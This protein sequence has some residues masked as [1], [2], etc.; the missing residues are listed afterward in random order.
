MLGVEPFSLCRKLG[1][2]SL[3]RQEDYNLGIISGERLY[4]KP[5]ERNGRKRIR[6]L[7]EGQGGTR[8]D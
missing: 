7:R 1:F 5:P 6:Y 8:K 3:L 2:P 4:T